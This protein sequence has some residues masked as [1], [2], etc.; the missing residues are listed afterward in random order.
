MYSFSELILAMKEL[1]AERLVLKAGA[2]P[3]FFGGGMRLE[4]RDYS[5]EL[6]E[7]DC[8]Q[9]ILNM[10]TDEDKGKLEREGRVSAS[11]GVKG[12]GQLTV[13]ASVEGGKTSANIVLVP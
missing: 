4:A 13:E 10:L 9:I 8:R 5:R 11:F 1:K 7:Q 3:H 12:M 2:P 6:S